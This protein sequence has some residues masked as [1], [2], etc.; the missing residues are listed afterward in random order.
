VRALWW[1]PIALVADQVS[2]AVIM[3]T[4]VRGQSV[5]LVGDYFRLTYIH[6]SGAAFGL[7]LGSPL[8]H[9]VISVVALGALAWLFASTSHGDRVIRVA[10]S[11]VMGGAVG[12]IVDRIHLH[13]VVDFLDLGV[14]SLRWPVF[15]LA[16]SFVTVG[17][18][19]LALAYWRHD[20]QVAHQESDSASSAEE[21]IA[22]G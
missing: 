2:K 16:D 11:M 14:G 9:T 4:M 5:P 20:R 6:N 19:L 15:N 12:N 21:R 8:L 1:A 17:V 7:N 13:E 3:N 22:Q 18:A 10:L